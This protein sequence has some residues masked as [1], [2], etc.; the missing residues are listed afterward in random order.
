VPAKTDPRWSRAL[1]GAE[2]KVNS[3]ATKLLLTRLR[4]EVKR[5]PGALGKSA[6]QLHEFFAANPFAARDLAAL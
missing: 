6:S 5:D 4:D 2:P 1:T 3:L